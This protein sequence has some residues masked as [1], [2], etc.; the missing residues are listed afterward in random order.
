MIIIGICREL[1]VKKVPMLLLILLC[2]MSAY[3]QSIG[4]PCSKESVS[5]WY[6]SRI[7]LN[8]VQLKPH[9]SIDKEELAK[10]YCNNPNW[11]NKAFEFL[12]SNDLE[13]LEP[14]KYVIEEGNVTAFVSEGPPKNMEE[15]KWETHKNFNDLQY[16]VKGQAGMGVASLTNSKFQAT[17]MYDSKKDVANY[18]VDDGKFHKAK[19]GTFFIFSPLD[20]H[21]PAFK[22]KGYDSIKKILIKVRVP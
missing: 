11:W 10:Q 16:I 20:I 5:K 13:N 17:E 19:P 12:A 7:W 18:S 8:G 6:K 2:T 9:K 1:S 14:G 21:R 3:S 15:I 4:T 22:L